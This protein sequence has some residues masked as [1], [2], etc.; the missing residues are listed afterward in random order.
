MHEISLVSSLLDQ[1]EQLMTRHNAR[2]VSAIRVSI[3]EFAGVEY[4]LFESAYEMLVDGSRARGAK[5]ELERVPLEARCNRCGCEFAV[6][7]FRFQCPACE[8]SNIQVLRGEELV[9]EH[10]TLDVDGE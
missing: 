2:G 10:V 7:R 4:E 3:G 1:V 9:L 8:S 6:K 5:L